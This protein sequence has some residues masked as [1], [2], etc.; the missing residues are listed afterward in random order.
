MQI[1][2]LMQ[3]SPQND[4][5]NLVRMSDVS[6]VVIAYLTNCHSMSQQAHRISQIKAK[7]QG[8]LRSKCHQLESDALISSCT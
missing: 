2:L 3:R 7:R 6:I 1:P 4:D 8:S 5:K